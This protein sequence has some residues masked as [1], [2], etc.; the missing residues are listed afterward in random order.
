MGGKKGMIPP[1]HPKDVFGNIFGLIR[2]IVIIFLS[3]QRMRFIGPLRYLNVVV[4][5]EEKFLESLE[6]YLQLK[7]WVFVRIFYITL[8]LI[9]QNLNSFH[10]SW[11]VIRLVRR[12]VTIFCQRKEQGQAYLSDTVNILVKSISRKFSGDFWK[13]VAAQNIKFWNM[14]LKLTL[15]NYDKTSCFELQLFFSCLSLLIE[16]ARSKIE[17]FVL[18]T[19]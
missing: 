5:L 4:K 10:F 6:K 12:M 8:S 13:K 16:L 3:T 2:R 18:A 17:S 1:T 19:F 11:H 9:F 7:K 14:K 15:E